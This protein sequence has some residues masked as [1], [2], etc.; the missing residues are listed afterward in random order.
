MKI[1][2]SAKVEE[3]VEVE[4]SALVEI[5]ESKTTRETPPPFPGDRFSDAAARY[6]LKCFPPKPHPLYSI[7][8]IHRDDYYKSH[9]GPMTSHWAADSIVFQLYFLGDGS[10]WTV[11]NSGRAVYNPEKAA[12]VTRDA[13]RTLLFS[14]LDLRKKLDERISELGID[15]NLLDAWTHTPHTIAE[16]S[17]F[18]ALS[19]EQ[20]MATFRKGTEPEGEIR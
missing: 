13:A 11:A 5:S 10:F 20:K 16:G 9:A 3:L 2:L 4:S 1:P 7:G 12:F 14:I 19:F 18:D 17:S 8:E 15:A 6:W